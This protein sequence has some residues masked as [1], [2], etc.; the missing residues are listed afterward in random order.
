MSICIFA[1]FYSEIWT[2]LY[3]EE[4]NGY[5]HL[6]DRMEADSISGNFFM[7]LLTRIGTWVLIFTNFVPISLIVTLEMVKFLH[8]KFI[9][10]DYLIYDMEKDQAS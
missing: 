2:E 1:A 9:S 6:H 10:Y 8:A 3:N 4:T 5:L 7:R